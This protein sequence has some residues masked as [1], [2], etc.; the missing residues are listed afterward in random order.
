[1]TAEYA[2]SLT[3]PHGAFWSLAYTQMEALPVLQ[4]ASV[5]GIWGISF[6]LMF[7]PSA[8]A[9]LVSPQGSM[10]TTLR[11]GSA[12]A[13]LVVLAVGFGMWRLNSTPELVGTITVGLAA[14]DQPDHPLPASDPAA[15][16]ALR[17]YAQS[18][19]ALAERGVRLAVLP[20]TIV[21]VSDG[22]LADV[23]ALFGSVATRNRMDVV[24]GVDRRSEADEENSAL[25]F[26][27]GGAA[28][29][30]YEKHHLLPDFEARYRPGNEITVLQGSDASRGVAIC[31]D[32]DFPSLG[33]EYGKR[34]VTLLLVPAWDFDRDGWLHSRMAIMRGVESGFAI[35]RSAR[36]GALT[37]SDARGRVL[38]ETT[39][40]SA[41]VA[42][43][44]ATV[45]LE[46]VETIYSRLGDWFAWLSVAVLACSLAL[47]AVRRPSQATLASGRAEPAAGET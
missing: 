12:S 24:V 33:R 37:L 4:L 11:L 10:R 16:D 31:K 29:A 1:V 42:T 25:V 23:E 30:T 18:L 38:A 28:P 40:A 21:K 22:E 19:D 20:E 27:P 8:V 15:Q 41:P 13:A 32:M 3:S 35:A 7:V 6:L 9:V 43:V 47:L 14:A 5:F 34:G 17:A 26:S 45:P 36:R 39:S 44:L 2:V 46:R